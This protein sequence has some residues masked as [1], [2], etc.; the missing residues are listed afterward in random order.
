MGEEPEAGGSGEFGEHFSLQLLG[1]RNEKSIT[2]YIRDHKLDLRQTAY[3]RGEHKGSAWFVLM[4]GI[5]PDREAAVL[6]RDRLPATV[7]KAKPWPRTL[8]S[9]HEAIAA[10][11]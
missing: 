11:P 5:Y 4:Y 6:G 1:S 8:K 2:D 3:Y 9:V 7:R 10:G